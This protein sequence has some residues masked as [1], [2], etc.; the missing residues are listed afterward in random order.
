[1]KGDV[2]IAYKSIDQITNK[3]GDTKINAVI[4]DTRFHRMSYCIFNRRFL[5]TIPS[6][7]CLEK[8]FIS[9]PR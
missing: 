1:L 7:H 6:G 4:S 8:N 9:I 2:E 3:P 5:K